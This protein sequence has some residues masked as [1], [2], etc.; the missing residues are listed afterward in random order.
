MRPWQEY[1]LNYG[2]ATEDFLAW[3]EEAKANLIRQI[4]DAATSGDSAKITP[5]ANEL[6]VYKKIGDRFRAEFRER[7]SQIERRQ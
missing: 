2:P 7:Q 1:L 6:T 5:L 4:E 3:I